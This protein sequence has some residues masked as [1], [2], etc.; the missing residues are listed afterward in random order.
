MS[1]VSVVVAECS[2]IRGRAASGTAMTQ[3]R[4]RLMIPFMYSDPHNLLPTDN[5]LI[6][7]SLSHDAVHCRPLTPVS[8]TI[9]QSV[10]YIGES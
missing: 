1:C 9:G 10:G 3:P 4:I 5:L 6:C 2:I 8:I 7:D